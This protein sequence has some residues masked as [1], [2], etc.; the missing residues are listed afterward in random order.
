LPEQPFF[1]PVL[2]EKYA[3][4]IA[5]DWNTKDSASGFAGYVLRFRVQNAFL[6]RYE[7][8]T[9]GSSNHQEYWIPAGELAQFNENIVGP[10][11]V[12]AEF[13]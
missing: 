10:I 11:E 12:M 13:P 3:T 5:R 7:I 6:S 1:Y 2:N 9:V 4:Q 8:Q